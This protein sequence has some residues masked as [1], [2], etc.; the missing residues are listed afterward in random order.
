MT[1]TLT[2]SESPLLLDVSVARALPGGQVRGLVRDFAGSPLVARIRIEPLGVEVP[3]GKDGTFE[4]NVAP[5]AYEVVIHAEGYADQKRRIV[6][7]RDGV[8]MLN[9]ELR[10]GR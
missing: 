10:K 3:V 4:T 9:V 8:T 1:R 2:L 6:V 5:G 7:E